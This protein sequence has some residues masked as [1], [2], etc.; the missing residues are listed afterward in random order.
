M[1]CLQ[2]LFLSGSMTLAYAAV[3]RRVA[4]AHQATGFALAQSFM[5]LGLGLGPMTGAVVAS[6]DGHGLRSVFAVAGAALLLAGV[7]MLLLRVVSP[8]HGR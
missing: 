8:P 2:A 5:Q 6:S 7:A 1:R 3:T 4:L